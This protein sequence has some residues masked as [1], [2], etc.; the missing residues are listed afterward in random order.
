MLSGPVVPRAHGCRWD[1]GHLGATASTNARP[2][3]IFGSCGVAHACAAH[4]AAVTF[5]RAVLLFYLQNNNDP[6]F[7]N[8]NDGDL[9]ATAPQFLADTPGSFVLN[10]Y[11]PQQVDLRDFV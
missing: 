8:E 11:L 6:P 5:T 1:R 10:P 4:E 2:Q 7:V 9:P 3:G